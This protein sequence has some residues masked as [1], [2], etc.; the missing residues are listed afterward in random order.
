LNKIKISRASFLFLDIWLPIISAE[1]IYIFIY[2]TNAAASGIM[3]SDL[4]MASLMLEHIFASLGALSGGV[5]AIEA[6]ILQKKSN[7]M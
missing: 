6:A 4:S 3:P 7:Q 2:I 1:L 5:Y